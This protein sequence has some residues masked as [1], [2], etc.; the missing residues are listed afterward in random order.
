M[1]G[2]LRRGA[3]PLYAGYSLLGVRWGLYQTFSY[4]EKLSSKHRGC[5]RGASAPLFLNGQAGGIKT[6][7]ER[8]IKGVS[9]QE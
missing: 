6:A 2:I 8:G 5:L 9:M 4:L 1:G 3:L 7:L